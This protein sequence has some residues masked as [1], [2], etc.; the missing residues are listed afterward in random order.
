MEFDY[1]DETDAQVSPDDEP[2]KTPEPTKKEE[3]KSYA[4]T[5]TPTPNEE[6]ETYPEPPPKEVEFYIRSPT[7]KWRACTCAEVLEDGKKWRIHYKGFA[8]KYDE[9]VESN[10]DRISMDNPG[11]VV[12]KRKSRKK[13]K[14]GY[15]D[16]EKR[17]WCESSSNPNI[18]RECVIVEEKGD[19]YKLHFISY[20]EKYDVWV[21]KNSKRLSG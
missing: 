10:S 8:D 17:I 13:V 15:E 6:E 11:T 21:E 5:V 14:T 19:K 20:H 16:N 9:I 1:Y 2:L 18:H 4:V 3:D 7:Q 12:P